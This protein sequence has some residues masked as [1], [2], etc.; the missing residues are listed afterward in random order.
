MRRIKETA[1]KM[2]DVVAVFYQAGDF[3][4]C[5]FG[6]VFNPNRAGQMVICKHAVYLEGMIGCDTVNINL[7]MLKESGQIFLIGHFNKEKRIIENERK[8]KTKKLR[9]T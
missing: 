2:Y 8:L 3:T 7:K 6:T 1:V 9:R 4:N 5:I